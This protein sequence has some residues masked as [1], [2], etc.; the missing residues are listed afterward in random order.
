MAEKVRTLGTLRHHLVITS[1]FSTF[2]FAALV[3]ASIF[4]PL[5]EALDH[6]EPAS[7]FAAAI[8]EHFLSLHARF[9]P[10]VLGAL[11]AS[12]G[13]G[14]LLYQRMAGPLVRYRMVYRQIA[15][16]RVPEAMAIRRY[17][18]LTSETAA[19][20]DL[21]EA[22]RARATGREARRSRCES[23]LDEIGE[24]AGGLDDYGRRA[25]GELREALEEL[26]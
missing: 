13:S 2:V 26:R 3:G 17:D 19:L 16:G 8:A 12:I 10:V 14:L 18:Y 15:E 24:Q 25:L 7:P 22:L 20:N 9:W 6:S 4:L 1:L 21:L 5:A 23:L 11:L